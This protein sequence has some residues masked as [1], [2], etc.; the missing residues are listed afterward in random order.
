MSKKDPFPHYWICS[1]CVKKKGGVYPKGNCSTGVIGK[2]GYCKGR[3]H[4]AYEVLIPVSDYDW[5]K[6]GIKHVWD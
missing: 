6:K 2:C 1:K 3:N 4:E 5:P